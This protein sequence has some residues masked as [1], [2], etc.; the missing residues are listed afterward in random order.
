MQE[1]VTYNDLDIKIDNVKFKRVNSSK[2]FDN[3]KIKTVNSSKFFG[4]II[5]EN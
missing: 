5:S 4:V 3:V 2:F 1:K